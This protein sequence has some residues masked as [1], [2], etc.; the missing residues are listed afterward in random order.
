MSRSVY[1]NRISWKLAALA[2]NISQ[3]AANNILD[4]NIHA[5]NFYANFLKLVYGWELVNA[6]TMFQ[7]TAAI[8]LIDNDKKLVVQVTSQNTKGKVN[9]TLSKEKLKEYSGYNL[10]IVIV[11]DKTNL[12]N[13][14]YSNPHNIEFTPK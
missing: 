6:N 8:D 10:K 11:V 13:E 14:S 12:K 5:E 9:A 4:Y 3:R 7:N 1:F 2:T